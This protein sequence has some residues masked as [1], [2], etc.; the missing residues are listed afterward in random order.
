MNTPKPEDFKKRLDE[1]NLAHDN[2]LS[3]FEEAS[4]SIKK[5]TYDQEKE[6][7]VFSRVAEVGSL[8]SRVIG[9]ISGY[10]R[11]QPLFITSFDFLK[12]YLAEFLKE[13]S[14][15]YKNIVIDL[16][17]KVG[18]KSY[19]LFCYVFF[20]DTDE[21]LAFRAAIELIKLRNDGADLIV[22]ALGSDDKRMQVI[23]INA[24]GS[25][26][27][28]YFFGRVD[29]KEDLHLSQ[30][31]AE[32]LV[33]ILQKYITHEEDD[34]RIVCLSRLLRLGL[35]D[36]ETIESSIIDTNPNVRYDILFE[37]LSVGI[38]EKEARA[39]VI[40]L[41]DPVKKISDLSFQRLTESHV[42]NP[43]AVLASVVD[44]LV[45]RKS[46][47]P[48]EFFNTKLVADVIKKIA[49]LNPRLIGQALHKLR[50]TAFEYHDQ[51]VMPRAVFVAQQLSRKEFVA[52]V[53]EKAI[54]L[55]VVA[56]K[57][58]MVIDS[59]LSITPI[60]NFVMPDFYVDPNRIVDLKSVSSN[61]F[62]LTKLIR[63][64]DELNSCYQSESFI[65]VIM[66]VRA[67]L[68]HVPPILGYKTFVEVANNYGGKSLKKS[69][70]NLQNSSRNIA[71]A[72]LHEAIRSKETLPNKTL[73]DFRNDLDVLLSEIVR[74]LK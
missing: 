12:P 60:P 23:A 53:G 25:V 43:E 46:G 2:L 64:C 62:D 55:P 30:E 65:S 49:E 18:D 5:G 73:V 51:P 34:V 50:D 63:F 27:N 59:G 40:S 71:D 48:K 13:G 52:L 68:D 3:V 32:N 70:L 74:L 61:N 19:D 14:S 6:K 54:E 67:I 9:N 20:N 24:I 58:L 16:L 1:Y 47:R 28:T 36:S 31:R 72:Y 41:E 42:R 22:Q 15:G 7:E 37:L 66:L 57:I 69:L 33:K 56:Q 11:F 29:E 10:V 8:A 35:L 17:E 4:A 38:G 45:I 44:E 26:V 21:R 39:F